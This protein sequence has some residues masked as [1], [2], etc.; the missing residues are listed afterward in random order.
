MHNYI[1]NLGVHILLLF[2]NAT[3]KLAEK[4][5]ATNYFSAILANFPLFGTFVAYKVAETSK[6][7]LK[8]KHY[9][10]QTIGRPRA[11]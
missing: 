7:K 10:Y 9:D 3:A 6:P 2:P 11:H 8:I 4:P 5:Q 1:Y